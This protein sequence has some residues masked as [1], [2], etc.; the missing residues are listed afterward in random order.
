MATTETVERDPAGSAA[1]TEM[2]AVDAG[3]P[4]PPVQP[5]RVRRTPAFS[6]DDWLSLGGA[7]LASFA[8]VAIGYSHIF[9]FSGILGFG[10]CWYLVFVVVYAGVV[11]A[12]NPRTIVVERLVSATLYLVAAVVMFALGTTIVY[13]FAKGWQA[14]VHLNFF[15]QDMAGVGPTAPLTKGGIYNAIVGTVVEVAIAVVVSVPLGLGTAVFMTEVGGRGSHLVRTVVESMTALPEILAGLFVYVFLVVGLGWSKSGLAVSA[16]MTVT[17]VPIVARAG[18]V[19]LRVVPGGCARPAAHSGQIIGGR[20][21]RSFCPVPGRDWR[22][23]SSCP[24]PVASGRP[25]SR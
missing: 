1:S 11:A 15:T 14:L 23:P 18:E 9:D 4:P 10:I 17:M 24:S 22:P 20:S 2:A 19:A 12:A 8:L 6:V 16:A 25:P 7:V 13:I 5:R 3:A 21:A